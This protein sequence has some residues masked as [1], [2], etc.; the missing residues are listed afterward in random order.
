M[1]T[2]FRFYDFT[3]MRV[4]VPLYLALTAFACR[5]WASGHDRLRV[6]NIDH[7]LQ[8]EAIFLQKRTEFGF[9]LDFTL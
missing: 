4:L 3:R 8:A 2:A 5:R 1:V 7:G 9:K 6:E